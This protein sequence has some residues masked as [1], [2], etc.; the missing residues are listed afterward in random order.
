MSLG[1]YI[2]RFSPLHLGHEFVINKML[3]EHGIARS[4]VLI[5]SC[6]SQICER[7]PFTYLD[8]RAFIKTIYPDLYIAG[9]PDYNTDDE[10]SQYLADLLFLRTVRMDEVTFYTG[11]E[12]DIICLIKDGF[13]YD[14][15]NRFDG[16]T[17]L[18]S[19]TQ[20]RQALKEDESIDELINPKLIDLVRSTFKIRYSE[21]TNKNEEK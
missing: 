11:I 1:V 12:N 5:G 16:S 17:P 20:V 18:I 2:G 4:I 15:M 13:S 7:T 9:I 21:L 8:R 10:W 6:N 19:A 14:V 3:K